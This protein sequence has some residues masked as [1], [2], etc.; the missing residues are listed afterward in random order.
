MKDEEMDWILGKDVWKYSW[1]MI[2]FF[3]DLR[4]KNQLAAYSFDGKAP[5]SGDVIMIQNGVLVPR[6]ID[7][8]SS[9][10]RH[11]DK[12]VDK[13][14]FYHLQVSEDGM[15]DDDCSP[16]VRHRCIVE[17][18]YKP[19]F[20][21]VSHRGDLSGRGW[22]TVPSKMVIARLRVSVDDH[23]DFGP[24]DGKLSVFGEMG[25]LYELICRYVE[26]G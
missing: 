2:D 14:V 25:H 9:I 15:D 19:K 11:P 21:S 23:V 1:D 26:K 8:G 16:I 22:L 3:N 10:L 20:E 24:R 7:E 4:A 12:L 17:K 18:L 6:E 13:D 5:G